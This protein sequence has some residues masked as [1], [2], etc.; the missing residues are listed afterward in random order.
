MSLFSQNLFFS[1]LNTTSY[2]KAFKY[3]RKH[4]IVDLWQGFEHVSDFE[5]TNVLTI[6]E[7]WIYQD[8]EYVRVLNML[9]F[10]NISDFWIYHGFTYARVTQ[11]SE[12]AW[13]I[14]GY[15]LLCLNVPKSVWKVFILH[16]P[17]TIHYRKEAKT[18]FLKSK[19]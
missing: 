13:K 3:F 19:N 10:P 17:F 9:L 6:K 2:L 12:Y 5:Y 8:C 18:V 15:R 7:S 14:L 4:F 1:Y 16:L 11:S